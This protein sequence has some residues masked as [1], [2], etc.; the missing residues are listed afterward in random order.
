MCMGGYMDGWV[1][2]VGR[3]GGHAGAGAGPHGPGPGPQASTGPGPL[4]LAA[5][6]MH[7]QVLGP[8]PRPLAP[9][10]GP[11]TRAHGWLYV[12]THVL[13][14]RPDCAEA[15]RAG[16]HPPGIGGVTITCFGGLP[17]PRPAMPPV[18]DPPLAPDRGVKTR[19]CTADQSM[20]GLRL[21]CAGLGCA[22]LH[23]AVWTG[24][25]TY[26]KNCLKPNALS[27]K[28]LIQRSSSQ[29]ALRQ[30]CMSHK[31]ATQ[32]GLSKMGPNGSKQS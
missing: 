31:V 25:W 3:V 5:G 20:R 19:R 15:R 17:A 18:P 21:G 30:T 12:D 16:S 32:T 22:E 14:P 29:H 26:T 11:G 6:P 28:N 4:A 8:G 23:G 13:R 7:A 2:G 24:L 10:R 27:Q 9:A 1:G